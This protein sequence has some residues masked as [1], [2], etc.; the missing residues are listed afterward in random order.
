MNSKLNITLA[1]IGFFL[2]VTAMAD[3]VHCPANL[4]AVE[5]DGNVLIAAP[6][7]LDGTTVKGSV[8]LFAGGSLVAVDATIIGNIQATAAD[9]VDVDR[10]AVEGSIQLDDTV[11]AVNSIR[12]STVIGS[13]QQSDSLSRLEVLGS[14][15]GA[16]IQVF[17]NSSSVTVDDNE[18]EGSVQLV[19]VL[20]GAS[21]VIDNSIN[22]GIQLLSNGSGF[23][24]R[25]NTVGADTQGFS[26]TGGLLIENNVIDGN[27]QCKENNPAPAGGN[28]QVSGNKE[29]QCA[30]LVPSTSGGIS[31]QG[32]GVVSQAPSSNAGSGSSADG[33]GGGA[34]GP[35]TA[36]SVLLLA[37]GRV[38]RSVTARTKA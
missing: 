4:G 15:I 26:N 8:E 31:A 9:F 6:C 16:D 22:G 38:R 30:N 20:S 7:R 14:V 37:I 33:S 21:G 13:V 5:V 29:D 10:S 23:D 2:S 32:G 24:V 1:G 36:V 27:L 34:L 35:L 18:I 28:N 12:N 11:G 19:D 17:S 3:D 25:G